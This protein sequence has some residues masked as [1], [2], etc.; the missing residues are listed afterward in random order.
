LKGENIEVGSG[1]E[2]V[3]QYPIHWEVVVPS[4]SLGWG[5]K[6]SVAVEEEKRKPVDEDDEEK[7]ERRD[8]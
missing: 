6:N 4:L 2:G 7:K 8:D 5:K 3:L 1:L